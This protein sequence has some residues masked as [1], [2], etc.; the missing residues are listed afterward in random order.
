VLT[1]NVSDTEETLYPVSSLG[2][3]PK[4]NPGSIGFRRKDEITAEL[5]VEGPPSHSITLPQILQTIP[6]NTVIIKIDIQVI[7]LFLTMS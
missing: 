3:D 4:I 5:M 6:Q 1:F 2:G 7:I